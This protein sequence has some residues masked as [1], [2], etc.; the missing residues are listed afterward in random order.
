MADS[1][2]ENSDEKGDF[3]NSQKTN[4]V[5]IVSSDE[6]D[7]SNPKPDIGLGVSNPRPGL[8]RTTFMNVASTAG[9]SNVESSNNNN[10]PRR[11]E[12]PISFKHFLNRDHSSLPATGGARPKIFSSSA[13]NNF[14]IRNTCSLPTPRLVSNPEL[15]SG[16]PDF[17]QDHLVIE[18]CYL[19]SNTQGSQISVDLDNLPDFAPVPNNDQWNYNNSRQQADIPFDLTSG[20]RERVNDAPLAILPLDLPESFPFDL[21]SASAEVGASKSLPDFLSDGPIHSD[22]R[23]D[24]SQITSEINSPAVPAVDSRHSPVLQMENE[25]LRQ[26]LDSTR[27]QLIDQLRR[28]E[29]LES[30]LSSLR[31]KEYEDTAGLEKMIEQVE[32]NL[33][34]TTKRAVTAESRVS[35]LKAEVKLLTNELIELKSQNTS[36]GTKPKVQRVAC[37]LRAAAN[38][39]ERSLRQLLGGVDNLRLIASTLENKNQIEEDPTDFL[40]SDSVNEPGPAL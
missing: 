19:S 34:R 35:K 28:N 24:N 25:R 7:G 15:T 23:N 8:R 4:R 31:S 12:T 21:P 38:S 33:K 2:E 40:D 17:V 1:N 26:E 20:Q 27:R 39:A 30:E 22:R 9:T 3:P 16:L 36:K 5:I 11:E 10:V 29:L 37:E 14:P 18:Q 32:D 13:T 6:E